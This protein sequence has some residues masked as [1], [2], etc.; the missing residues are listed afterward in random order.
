MKEKTYSESI[1]NAI[2]TFLK[3]DDWDFSFDDRWGL[4]KF[5]L[6]L[7]NKL[8]EVNYLIDVKKDEYLVYAISPLGVDEDNKKMMEVMA[9]FICRA[10]YGLQNGNF[11]LDMRDREVRFKCFVDCNDITPT[12]EIVKNSIYC[13]AAM[14][15]RY[16]DGI[17][18][19][20]F[21][22][23]EAKEAVEKCER[24]PIE[25]F[26]DS[27]GKGIDEGVDMNT[28]MARMAKKLEIDASKLEVAEEQPTSADDVIEAQT[29]CLE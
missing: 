14:F 17:G 9:E 13:P 25:E 7:K 6:G 27:L 18:G 12:P 10:N 22:N 20:I 3:E 19:I 21:G 8:K 2:N 4:F 16:G 28:M 23:L 15:E 29:D 1:A 26:C 11:E 5:G 24:T